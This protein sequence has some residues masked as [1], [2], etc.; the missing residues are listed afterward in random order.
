MNSIELSFDRYTSGTLRDRVFAALRSAGVNPQAF[1]PADLRE[2]DHFHTGGLQATSFVANSL[3]LG[4]G[5]RV[6]DVGAG[7]GGPARCFAMRGALVTGVDITAEFVDLARELDAN[8][9][10]D[11][12]ITMLQRPGHDTGLADAS[13]DAAV[14]MHVG[15]NLA[16]KPSVFAEVWRLLRP[17][18]VFGIYDLMG[19]NNLSYPMPWAERAEA[20]FVESAADY[21]GALKDAGFA[22]TGQVERTVEVLEVL[23]QMRGAL[24]AGTDPLATPLVLREDGPAAMANL[25][26]AI[27]SRQLVPLLMLASKPGDRPA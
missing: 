20:S 9:A 22:V 11:R 19:T 27:T 23:K 25:S 24:A 26:A 10:L 2:A 12:S 14:L 13:F 15:M 3:E 16:D 7:L 8:C 21:A 1:K 18:A 17:G 4:A 6:L 5:T